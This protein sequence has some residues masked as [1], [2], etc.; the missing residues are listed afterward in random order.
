MIIIIIIIFDLI[1]RAM[2]S[3]RDCS[4]SAVHGWVWP[5]L[6]ERAGTVTSLADLDLQSEGLQPRESF[7]HPQEERMPE[8]YLHTWKKTYKGD[9]QTDNYWIAFYY[10][11]FLP[12]VKMSKL[13]SSQPLQQKQQSPVWKHTD[14]SYSDSSSHTFTD[15]Q[16]HQH[17]GSWNLRA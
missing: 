6:W 12:K 11:L 2:L 5:C 13:K 7:Y 9:C 16:A 3:Y 8:I 17:T 1:N 10:T 14:S 15:H 4:V